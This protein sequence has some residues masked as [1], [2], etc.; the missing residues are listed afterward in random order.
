MR[1]ACSVI[2]QPDIQHI[3]FSI[4]TAVRNLASILLFALLMTLGAFVRIPL[5]WTPVP[6]TL[7]TFFVLLSGAVLGGLGGGVSQLVYLCVGLA[8]LPIFAGAL[9]GMTVLRGATAGYLIAFPIAAA[10]VGTIVKER[11][12]SV[13]RLVAAMIIA[14][15][16]I[17]TLGTLHL[18][19]LF[20]YKLTYA[21]QL[22]FLPFIGGDVA[23]LITAAGCTC[24]IRRLKV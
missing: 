20:G 3:G 17:L 4:N 23:K 18:A 5:P 24:W 14:N 11:E 22:G 16:M 9:G 8:G 1:L 15:L 13:A 7:Q 6:V 12:T 10:L 2:V 21:F 19:L